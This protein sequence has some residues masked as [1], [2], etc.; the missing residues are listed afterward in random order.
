[1]RAARSRLAT[2]LTVL[3]VALA[4]VTAGA[5]ATGVRLLVERSGSMRPAISPGDLVLARGVRADEVAV[6]DVIS[7]TQVRGGP[8]ITHRVADVRRVGDVLIFDTRGD[9]NQAAERWTTP[10]GTELGLVL[11]AVPVAGTAVSIVGTPFVAASLVAVALALL[12]AAVA[13]SRR[14]RRTDPGPAAAPAGVHAP[15]ARPRSRRRRP[16]GGR[17]G[18]AGTRRT[19]PGPVS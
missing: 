17:A 7:F 16:V 10:A 4:V 11:G 6:H 19:P 2:V 12:G 3:V 9:A 13:A 18:R 15:A 1:V 14:R 8:L 5:R